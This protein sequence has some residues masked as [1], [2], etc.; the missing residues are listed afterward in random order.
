MDVSKVRVGDKVQI[1]HGS[2]KLR[3]TIE[4]VGSAKVRIRTDEGAIVS[5]KPQNFRNFSAAARLAWKKMPERK[6]GRPR[7]SLRG[8]RISVTLRLDRALWSRFQLLERQHS[9]E[10]RVTLFNRFLAE[11]TAEQRPIN[12]IDF[13][14]KGQT[15]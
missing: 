6:V 13:G 15:S 1:T 5:E 8:E 7:G 2:R 4:N 3:G 11:L 9:I 14:K 12:E 10:D